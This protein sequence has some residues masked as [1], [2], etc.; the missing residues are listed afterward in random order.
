MIAYV[1]SVDLINLISF[2]SY[3]LRSQKCS[4]IKSRKKGNKMSNKD[5][6]LRLI[7][8]LQAVVLAFMTALFSIFAYAVMT[9]LDEKYRSTIVFCGM[10]FLLISIVILVVAIFISINKLEKMK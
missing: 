5:K 4:I 10:A 3:I 7:D 8:F 6:V 1:Y 2:I 9:V